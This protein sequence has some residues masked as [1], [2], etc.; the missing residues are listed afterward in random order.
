M[1][2][3][4]RCD[5]WPE[6]VVY[7]VTTAVEEKSMAGSKVARLWLTDRDFYAIT[8]GCAEVPKGPQ[9]VARF[10]EA[11]KW[12]AVQLA[13]TNLEAVPCHVV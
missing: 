5:P 2:V 13:I 7:I 8:K 6:V 12:R 10:K 1:I 4:M 3:K 9:R 11:L